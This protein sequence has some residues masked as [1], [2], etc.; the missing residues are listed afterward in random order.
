MNLPGKHEKPGRP[1]L[2]RS[3][4]KDIRNWNKQWN[5]VREKFAVVPTADARND[6]RPVIEE[7]A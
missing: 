5:T 2:G 3:L 1:P 4:E 7:L 6:L